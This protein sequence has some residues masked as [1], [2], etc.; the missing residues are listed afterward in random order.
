[1]RDQ[2]TSKRS[3]FS[4]LFVLAIQRATG[5]V[6]LSKNI[7]DRY[8][9]D[10]TPKMW[11]NYVISHLYDTL[12]D[13]FVEQNNSQSEQNFEGQNRALHWF[14]KD[15]R[16]YSCILMIL[17]SNSHI[18]HHVATTTV[19]HDESSDQHHLAKGTQRETHQNLKVRVCMKASGF[20][21]CLK[22][23]ATE[24]SRKKLF[25]FYLIDKPVTHLVS[26]FQN[27]PHRTFKV[28][29]TKPVQYHIV[30]SP[31]LAMNGTI[32]KL[33]IPYQ[34]HNNIGIVFS[35]ERRRQITSVLFCGRYS[36]TIIF[37]QSKSMLHQGLKP[38]GHF[39]IIFCVFDKMR[40]IQSETNVYRKQDH[41]SLAWL[42]TFPNKTTVLS[43]FHIKV[44]KQH[45]VLLNLSGIYNWTFQV[46][47][48]P[49]ERSAELQLTENQLYLS[50]RFQCAVYVWKNTKIQFRGKHESNFEINF[51]G[52]KHQISSSQHKITNQ[53][54]TLVIPNPNLGQSILCQNIL[55]T[56]S[57]YVVN[58]SVITLAY[59]GVESHSC[60]Y[61]GVG[62]LDGLD[63]AELSV[64]CEEPS[65][66]NKPRSIYSTSH[67]MI[68][69]YFAHVEYAEMSV[70]LHISHSKCKVT[71][72]NVCLRIKWHWVNLPLLHEGNCSVFYVTLN[73]SRLINCRFM[74]KPDQEGVV[75]S[76]KG[77]F[78]S[79]QFIANVNSTGKC[80]FSPT[81]E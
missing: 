16:H 59:E 67:A 78:T 9:L 36:K 55:S 2:I 63:F 8:I 61:A 76:M 58:M 56:L 49:G 20:E 17:S 41:Q 12:L 46:F 4:V 65:N 69:I 51:K 32:N 53:S 13:N 15:K 29:V 18:L 60:Q 23:G 57:S 52:Q 10:N 48:G 35:F 74:F 37:L 80:V 19:F 30:L 25:Y 73:K 14:P 24:M 38:F 1:M 34:C 22:N 33:F 3:A 75:Y 45:C 68:L 47:D 66:W 77:F 62:V 70:V 42:L 72:L 54:F 43:K 5:Q 81:K 7:T 50:K 26:F 64:L 28:D 21:L 31:Q 27:D 44:A 11:H 6:L 71:H 40:V 79:F 39:D